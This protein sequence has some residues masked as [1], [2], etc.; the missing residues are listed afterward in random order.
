[1]DESERP[2]RRRIVKVL[3]WGNF[4]EESIGIEDAGL[5]NIYEFYYNNQ[6]Y[7]D[8]EPLFILAVLKYGIEWETP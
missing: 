7:V 5:K 6:F 4:R 1:M 8:D 3:K 2:T